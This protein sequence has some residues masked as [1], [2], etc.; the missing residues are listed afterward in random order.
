MQTYRIIIVEDEEPARDLLKRYLSASINIEIIGEFADG[1]EAAKAINSL[2]PD[3]VLLDIQL[4]RLTGFEILEII[5]HPAA[6]IFTTAY[7][8]Y[9]LKAFERNAVDYLLKPFSRDRFLQALERA[10]ERMA[11]KS[12]PN[13][14]TL[15]ES[16][17]PN[18]PLNRIV[19][20][21]GKAIQ[22]VPIEQ[23][24]MIEASDDYVSIYTNQERFVKKQTM[25]YFEERLNP[26]T[27]IRTHRSYIVN[28]TQIASIELYEKDSYIGIL[29]NGN[30]VKISTSG[31]KELKEKLGI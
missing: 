24:E 12:A 26:E 22:V 13:L 28:I 17:T 3:L 21:T 8:E 1:F 31:Y 5:E 30:K 15:A 6:I 16:L 7:D 18:E 20:K 19:V 2:K 23:I 29:R 10:K 9:A 4:P 27:F 14:E 25:K 11:A